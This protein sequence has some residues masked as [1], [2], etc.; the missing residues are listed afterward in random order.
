[1]R[2]NSWNLFGNNITEQDVLQMGEVMVNTGMAEI[3]YEDIVMDTGWQTEHDKIHELLAAPLMTGKGLRTMSEETVSIFTNREMVSI[4]QDTSGW[5]AFCF[6]DEGD[7]EIWIKPLESNEKAVCLLNRS[8]RPR[9]VEVIAPLLLRTTACGTPDDYLPDDY[10]IRDVWRHE[11]LHEGDI[12]G[13]VVPPHGV[14]VLKFV[15]KDLRREEEL[16]ME[17]QDRLEERK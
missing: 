9:R 5:P 7:H 11:D 3:G 4:D 15:S 16:W 13:V 1:M 12:F 10:I 8:N 14:V 17:E 2:W 6:R